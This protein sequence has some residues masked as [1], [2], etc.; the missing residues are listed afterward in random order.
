VARVGVHLPVVAWTILGAI[1]WSCTSA[2]VG[3]IVEASPQLVVTGQVQD[4]DELL[5]EL[6][7]TL[8]ANRLE[9]R[10]T[11]R[12]RL[13]RFVVESISVDELSMAFDGCAWFGRVLPERVSAS[14]TVFDTAD[15][16]LWYPLEVSTP[17]VDAPG[18]PCH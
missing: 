9:E 18:E 3:P 1:G 8:I 6:D 17:G 4:R 13:A 7:R 12:G 14:V 15:G 5:A 16:L 2:G 10:G 11:Y